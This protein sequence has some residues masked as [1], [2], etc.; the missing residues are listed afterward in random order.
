M[1]SETIVIIMLI[2]CSLSIDP[3]N[4]GPNASVLVSPVT[5][6]VSHRN[7]NSLNAGESELAG[8]CGT[9]AGIRN[10]R[11]WSDLFVH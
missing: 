8:V 6:L 5:H 3:L 10:R 9:E 1:A 11:G 7:S 2:T 4:R